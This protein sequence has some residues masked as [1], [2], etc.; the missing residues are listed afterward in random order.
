MTDRGLMYHFDKLPSLVQ[1]FIAEFFGV[2]LLSVPISKIYERIHPP[3]GY[4]SLPLAKFD[5]VFIVLGMLI[6]FWVLATIFRP[7][8]HATRFVPVFRAGGVIVGNSQMAADYAF[9]STHPSYVFV[10]ILT[11]AF[12]WGVRWLWKH[13]WTERTYEGTAMLV[14]AVAIPTLRLLAWYVLR[15]R[16]DGDDDVQREVHVSWIPVAMLYGLFLV[17]LAVLGSGFWFYLQHKDKLAEANL[18]VVD[19][20][21]WQGNETFNALLDPKENEAVTRRIRLRAIQKSAVATTCTNPNNFGLFTT[22]IATLG[23]DDV[24]LFTYG[25]AA[26]DIDYFV[27][28]TNG[29]QGKTVEFTGRLKQMPSQIPSWKKYCGLEK[30]SRRPYWVFEDLR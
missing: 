6:Y 5:Y 20:S 11:A 29:N 22:A 3:A 26:A 13:Y 18:T 27:K 14:I 23:G 15:L 9:S 17:P 24:L 8:L 30:L 12:Y 1:I 2:M 10:D 19:A 16:P 7:A 25:P 21:T 28:R 4:Q